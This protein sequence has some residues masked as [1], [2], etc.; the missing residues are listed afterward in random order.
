MYT[1]EKEWRPRR[2]RFPSLESAEQEDYRLEIDEA[3]TSWVRIS[4]SALCVDG[5]EMRRKLCSYISER[6][7]FLVLFRADDMCSI[8]T[9]SFGVSLGIGKISQICEM[10]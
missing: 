6:D 1:P 5:I 8:T 4:G 2:E 10:R 7:R 3:E 9:V